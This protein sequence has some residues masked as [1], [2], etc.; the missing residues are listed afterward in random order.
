MIDSHLAEAA[1]GFLGVDL[2]IAVCREP[3]PADTLAPGE[4]RRLDSFRHSGR[5]EDWLRGRGALKGLLREL[6]RPEDTSDLAFPHPRFS[7]T[8]AAGAGIAAGIRGDRAFGLGVDFEAPRRLRPETER[9]YLDP[10][11]RKALAG[12]EGERDALRLRLWTLKEALFKADPENKGR[13]LR[14]YRLRNPLADQGVAEGPDADW[15]FRYV[16]V[17]FESGF[18]SVAARARTESQAR[19]GP[20]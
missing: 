15:I 18:L 19:F 14:N 4:K 13:V 9:F 5:R 17:A 7:L 2:V 1:A 20:V 16:S 11:E 3:L 10:R 12:F 6:G 8:H